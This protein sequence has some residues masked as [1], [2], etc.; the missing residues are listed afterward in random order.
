MSR[1]LTTNL[2]LRALENQGDKEEKP[3]KPKRVKMEVDA[4]MNLD[5]P[6]LE[7]LKDENQQLKRD[8]EYLATETKAKIYLLGIQ[9]QNLGIGLALS[10]PVQKALN[11]VERLLKGR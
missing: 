2:H 9:P 10:S 3:E 11:E 6:E 4:V 1:H 8:I 7:S 5:N